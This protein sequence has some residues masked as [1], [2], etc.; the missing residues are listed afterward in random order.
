MIN[1][2]AGVLLNLQALGERPSEP[3]YCPSNS[4]T[5]LAET[6]EQPNDQQNYKNGAKTDAQAAACAPLPVAVPTAATAKDQQQ[7]D[8]QED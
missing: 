8:D 2:F 4:R 3:F 6:A 7:N 1:S 5:A